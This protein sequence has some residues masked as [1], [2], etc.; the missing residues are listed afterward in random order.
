[1]SMEALAKADP[2]FVKQIV[3]KCGMVTA[4]EAST[5]PVW[6]APTASSNRNRAGLGDSGVNSRLLFKRHLHRDGKKDRI[7]YLVSNVL[8]LFYSKNASE[9]P[10]LVQI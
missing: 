3:A 8:L 10:F 6:F 5:A 1:M 7:C 2:K 4:T 9:L